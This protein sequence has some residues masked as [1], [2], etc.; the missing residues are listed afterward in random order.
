MPLLFLILICLII[1]ALTLENAWE[2]V[3]FY[4]VPDLSKLNMKTI[5]SA[6]GQ[7]FFSL[8]LGMGALITYGSYIKQKENI[9]KAA[10]TVTIADTAVAFLAGLL[11][12]PLVFSQG[13]EPT[14]GPRLVFIALPTIFHEMGPIVGRFVGGGFFLLLCFAALTSTISLLEV[15][16]AYFV[17]EK[18]MHRG[19]VTF[20]LALLIF[21]IGLPSM[22][23]EGA[24]PFLTNFM[25]YE[26]AN[27]TFL[28]VVAD[29]FSELALL[30]GGFLLSVFI[31][32]KW[33]TLNFSRELTKGNP[34][35]MRSRLARF[36][37]IMIATISPFLLGSIFVITVLQ[38]FFNIQLFD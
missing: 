20:A 19:K 31:A 26:G 7:S 36:V 24:V 25:H 2:G 22:L 8:S 12:F 18:K 4:L 16:V 6:L 1:H 28:D 32:Y 30:L 29:I 33:G 38:K 13:Q 37:N 23:S 14:A 3:K 27:K 9:I 10:A 15:P 11:I 35:Y 21:V 34:G 17:D 5:Y